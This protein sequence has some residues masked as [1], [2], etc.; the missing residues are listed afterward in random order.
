MA[1]ARGGNGGTRSPE[2][3]RRVLLLGIL[4]AAAVVTGRAFQLGV[5]EGAQWREDAL[6]QQG[7]VTRTHLAWSTERGSPV[8]RT[9]TSTQSSARSGDAG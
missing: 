2:V 9:A 3:R 7:D 1:N 4:A 5:L 8:A 6:A